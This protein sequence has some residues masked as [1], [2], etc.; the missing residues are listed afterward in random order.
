MRQEAFVETLNALRAD[1]GSYLIAWCLL[2]V[3]IYLIE[4]CVVAVRMYR[5]YQRHS[6][7]ILLVRV[8]VML[9]LLWPVIFLYLLPRVLGDDLL[10]RFPTLSARLL[11]ISEKCDQ[12]LTW[13]FGKLIP[14]RGK[15]MN[16]TWENGPS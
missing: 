4:S 9:G 10:L 3:W 5:L 14:G 6:S 15:P 7:G 1:I 16:H 2:A 11:V 8:A 13:F 12:T